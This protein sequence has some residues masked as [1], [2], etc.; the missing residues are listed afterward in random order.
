MSAERPPHPAPSHL[1]P[2]VHSGVLERRGGN[3]VER[4]EFLPVGML[5]ADDYF[6]RT[7]F[8]TKLQPP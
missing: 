4:V 5:H 7:S 1:L 2:L 8:V 3:T 6:R